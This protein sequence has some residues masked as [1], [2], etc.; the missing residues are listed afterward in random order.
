MLVDG[1]HNPTWVTPFN[2]TGLGP[3]QH[4]VSVNKLGFA[5]QTRTIDVA[6]GSK[7]FLVVELAAAGATLSVSSQPSGAEL[8]LD[9]KATGRTTPLQMQ[10]DR[11]G[12][13]SLMVR[14]PGYL[15][16]TVTANLQAGQTFQF[17]PELRELGVTDNI[18]IGGR[19]K[20]I[21]GGSETAGT[22][23]VTVRTQPKGA[24]VA[25]N[26]HILDKS[27]P[28]DFYLKPGLYVIDLT[29]SGYKSAQRVL[30]VDKNGKF[31]VEETLQPR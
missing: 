3:G 27:A 29:L 18:V 16:E 10:I 21:F 11:P 20:K 5:P 17:A 24:Q 7:S 4:I 28:V 12:N 15:E 22:A 9:G 19:F 13:H 6:S 8:F 30:N 26:H 1:H 23:M 25:V 31:T 14:K 2:M